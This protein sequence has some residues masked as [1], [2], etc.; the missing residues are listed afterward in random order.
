MV[1]LA[2]FNSQGP[3]KS[4]TAPFRA[5]LRD[6]EESFR[7][8][9]QE[10]RKRIQDLETSVDENLKR[11]EQLQKDCVDVFIYTHILGVP[12]SFVLLATLC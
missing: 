6:T 5:P 12:A 9:I 4:P 7:T 10:Q 8:E 11:K 1:P 2:R 3:L